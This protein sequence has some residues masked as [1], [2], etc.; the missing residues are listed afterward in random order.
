LANFGDNSIV[1]IP[2]PDT[3]G[4]GRVLRNSQA[5][6]RIKIPLE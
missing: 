2:K 3:A 4:S 5:I 6:G 1:P